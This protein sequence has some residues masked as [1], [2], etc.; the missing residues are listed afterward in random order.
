MKKNP[1]II[2]G[3]WKMNP[4]TL[5][6][7]KRIARG[8]KKTAEEVKKVIT[9]MCPPTV[10][11]SAVASLSN[12]RYLYTGVQN[13]FTETHGAYTGEISAD[14]ARNAGARFVIVGHSERRRMGETDAVVNK[15]ILLALTSGLNPIICIGEE[16]HDRDGH[17]LSVIKEQVHAALQ[18]VA[19]VDIPRIV[20]AYEPIWAVGADKAMNAHD[21][22]VMT[23]LIRKTI[24]DLYKLRKQPK[25]IHIPVLY[26]GSVDPTNTAGILTEGSAD[27]LLVGRQSLDPKAFSDIL[28]IANAA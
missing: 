16:N 21:V 22:H 24:I 23:I 14:M 1:K 4:Q 19:L 26:G 2:V 8:V 13:I 28:R 3:N 25:Q 17:Y 12:N 9:I 6:E 11:T 10:F 20:I 27:G 5:D 15:K 18:N 7:A